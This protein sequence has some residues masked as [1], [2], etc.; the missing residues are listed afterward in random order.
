MDSGHGLHGECLAHYA[1]EV[2][3][4]LWDHELLPCLTEALQLVMQWTA[5]ELNDHG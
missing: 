3:P 5:E 2:W 4:K 1:T